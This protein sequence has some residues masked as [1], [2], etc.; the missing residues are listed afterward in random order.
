MNALHKTTAGQG[1]STMTTS[2][3]ETDLGKKLRPILR[4][5]NGRSDDMEAS[6]VVS[7]D[8]L[9]LAA[10]LGDSV[11]PDRFG[12]MCASLL[13]LANRAAQEIERGELKQVLVEGENGVML[14]VRAGPDSV[15]AVAA[16]P[17]INLGMVF[18]EAR[19]VATKIGATRLEN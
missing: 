5:L 11:D 3:N 15:L 16:K 9:T 6:A 8:G 12:A 14:L 17:T 13:A 2:E 19:K 7:G 1:G 4:E 10:V 18:I